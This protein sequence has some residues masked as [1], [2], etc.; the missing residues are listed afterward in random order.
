MERI[1][2]IPGPEILESNA[3]P[4]EVDGIFFRFRDFQFWGFA[5][6]RG[7]LYL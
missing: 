7:F 3:L 5:F 6:L 2:I 4:G 1:N